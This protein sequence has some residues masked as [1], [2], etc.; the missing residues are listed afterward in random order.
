MNKMKPRRKKRTSRDSPTRKGTQKTTTFDWHFCALCGFCYLLLADVVEKMCCGRK[1][2]RR[3]SS[4]QIS[5][6]VH[7]LT[8]HE[9]HMLLAYLTMT[10]VNLVRLIVNLPGCT[11][12]TQTISTL[13]DLIMIIAP[14]KYNVS[15]Y[16]NK[17]RP[18]SIL[19]PLTF[20]VQVWKDV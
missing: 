6:H 7:H 2:G 5:H 1:S 16:F 13:I 4:P 14:K 19:P 18:N 15:K 10:W 12:R 11:F 20:L 3:V 8:L 9:R 17:V